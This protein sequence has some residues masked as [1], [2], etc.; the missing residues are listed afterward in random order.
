MRSSSTSGPDGRARAAGLEDQPHRQ[1]IVRGADTDRRELTPESGGLYAVA[2][3]F[4]AISADDF[5]NM[6]RHFAVYDALYAYCQTGPGLS[7]RHP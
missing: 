6:A 3:G 7:S 4:R 5:E 1:V 2:K